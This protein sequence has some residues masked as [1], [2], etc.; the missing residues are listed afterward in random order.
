M[1][2]RQLHH[3]EVAASRTASLAHQYLICLRQRKVRRTVPEDCV[4][5][6]TVAIDD[7]SPVPLSDF[8][9]QSLSQAMDLPQKVSSR[10]SRLCG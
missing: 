4:R 10:R 9:I 8:A 6:R 7:S 1:I 5:D 3:S 2:N